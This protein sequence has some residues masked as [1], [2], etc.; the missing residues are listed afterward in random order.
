MLLS[1]TFNQYLITE[2]IFRTS[3][4]PFEKIVLVLECH[5]VGLS[6]NKQQRFELLVYK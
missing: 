2:Q 1:V 3:T 6:L 4:L 5:T